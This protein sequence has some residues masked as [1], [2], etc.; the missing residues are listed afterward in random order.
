MALIGKHSNSLRILLEQ[1]QTL[2]HILFL[3]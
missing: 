1:R 2:V 3:I